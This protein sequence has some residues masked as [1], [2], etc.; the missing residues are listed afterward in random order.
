MKRIPAC[1]IPTEKGPQGLPHPVKC[2][3]CLSGSVFPHPLGHGALQLRIIICLNT[4]DS[5]P[6]GLPE[7]TGSHSKAPNGQRSSGTMVTSLIGTVDGA[8]VILRYRP[9]FLKPISATPRTNGSTSG[10]GKPPLG[11]GW[12]RSGSGTW[13]ITSKAHCTAL[14]KCT[15]SM[16]L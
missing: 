4:L 8:T 3:S 7:Q 14:S 1:P 5:F 6:P 15:E 9:V 10:Y 13:R 16:Y 12:F 11:P 2:P